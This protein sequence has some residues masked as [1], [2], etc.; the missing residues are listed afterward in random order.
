ALPAALNLCPVAGNES[1][2]GRRFAGDACDPDKI[3]PLVVPDPV[4]GNPDRPLRH[5][6]RRVFLDVWWRLPLDDRTGRR[7]E[8]G[9]IGKGLVN[10]ALNHRF[11]AFLLAASGRGKCYLLR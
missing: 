6:F 5:K 8:V 3:V 10:W 9:R 1:H 4:A 7:I 11:D 2:S